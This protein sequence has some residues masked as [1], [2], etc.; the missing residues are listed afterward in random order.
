LEKLHNDFKEQFQDILNM[1]IPDWIFDPFSNM[2]TAHLSQL[3]EELLE[4]TTNQEIK[5]KF[6]N[7]YHEFW[8]K[9]PIPQLYP[10]IWSIVQ[11]FLI[12]FPSSYLSEH[13]FSAVATLLT[14]K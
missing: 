4:L 9:K 10:E 5:F 11:R 2:I 13:G 3:K 14:K 7:G 1:K 8:L 6:K 12:P